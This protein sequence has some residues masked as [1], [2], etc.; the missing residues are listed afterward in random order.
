MSQTSV[1]LASASILHK[2]KR[3]ISSVSQLL[4]FASVPPLTSPC[5]PLCPHAASV[6]QAEPPTLW[7]SSRSQSPWIIQISGLHSRQVGINLYELPQGERFTVVFFDP[8]QLFYVIREIFTRDD[9]TNRQQIVLWL[10]ATP[11]WWLWL[12]LFLLRSQSGGENCCQTNDNNH[13]VDMRNQI[14]LTCFIYCLQ[15]L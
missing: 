8:D 7:R 4:G 14:S 11:A 10:Q 13:T 5:F 2:Q 12:L 6:C 15:R 9:G 1:A 3:V